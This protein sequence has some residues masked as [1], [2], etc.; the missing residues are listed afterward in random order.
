MT[1]RLRFVVAAPGGNTEPT[2]GPPAVATIN[3]YSVLSVPTSR[4][5]FVVHLIK[6]RLADV[7]VKTDTANSAPCPSDCPVKPQADY[8]AENSAYAAMNGT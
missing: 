3:G 2:P 8:V 1:S 5:T 7:S 4:G 6:E